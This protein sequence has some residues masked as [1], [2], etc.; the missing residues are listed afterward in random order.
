[1]LPFRANARVIRRVSAKTYSEVNDGRPVVVRPIVDE[2]RGFFEG[3]A[4]R[5]ER[6]PLHIIRTAEDLD[7]LPSDCRVNGL[8]TRNRVV[9]DIP[10]ITRGD[11]IR[12]ET[13]LNR[14]QLRCGCMTGAVCFLVALVAGG[15]YFVNNSDSVFSIVF[16]GRACL[17][18]VASAVVGFAAKLVSLQVTRF[19]FAR[20]CRRIWQE[21]TVRQNDLR[22][23]L[24]WEG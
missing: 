21:I 10:D 19:Q 12:W 14:Y 7:I 17:F 23:G 16:L 22:A 4:P 18:F 1:M 15:A 2:P 6:R 13:V 9:F 24:T 11:Q 3:P 20:A 8:S 5:E